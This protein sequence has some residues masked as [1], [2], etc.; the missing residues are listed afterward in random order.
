[1]SYICILGGALR[2]PIIRSY[3]RRIVSLA[4]RVNTSHKSNMKGKG[5]NIITCTV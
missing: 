5:F 1:M 4:T 3:N 2:S